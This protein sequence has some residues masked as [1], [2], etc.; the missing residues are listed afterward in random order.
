MNGKIHLLLLL[1]L[2]FIIWC[3]YIHFKVGNVFFRPNF[4]LFGFTDFFAAPFRKY[5]EFSWKPT[6]WDVNPYIAL[7]LIMLF[8]SILNRYTK[9]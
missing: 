8:L 2:S 1:V 4:V 3:V 7:P 9:F 5:N 6:Y